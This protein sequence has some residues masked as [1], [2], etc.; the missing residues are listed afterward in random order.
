M[1]ERNSERERVRER[2]SERARYRESEGGFKEKESA[3]NMTRFFD[4][5]M[6]R[7]S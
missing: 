1:R 3:I 5:R 7:D 4:R 6:R 2:N